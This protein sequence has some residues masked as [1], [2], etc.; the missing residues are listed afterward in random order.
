MLSRL[1]LR[2][3][4]IEALAPTGAASFPTIAGRLVYDSRIDNI[5]SLDALETERPMLVVYTEEAQASSWGSGNTHPDHEVVTLSVEAILA[6]RGK[7]VVAGPDGKSVEIGVLETG[8]TDTQREA[9]LDILE[10]Q[11]RRVFDSR[12]YVASQNPMGAIVLGVE[13]IQSV[14]FRDAENGIRLAQRSIRFSLR[15]MPDEWPD[16][17]TAQGSGLDALPEPLRSLAKALPAGSPHLAIAEQAAG[18]VPPAPEIAMLEAVDMFIAM[19]RVP[20]ETDFDL[21]AKAP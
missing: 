18:L 13:K 2:M 14:P 11:V 12:N 9:L 20:T 19:D 16:P 17:N 5:D 7:T 1:V 3:A 6:T 15:I 8:V 4:A 21:R 10:G